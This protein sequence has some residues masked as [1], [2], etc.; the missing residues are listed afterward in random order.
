MKL[1]DRIAL[2]FALLTS[3]IL[4]LMGLLLFVLYRNYIQ[5][6]FTTRLHERCLIAA[7]LYFDREKLSEVAIESIYQKHLRTLPNEQEYI[8]D[9]EQKDSMLAYLPSFLAQQLEGPLSKQQEYFKAQSQDTVGVGILY[10]DM[11]GPHF[12]VVTAINRQ[13]QQE[14]R[15]LGNILAGLAGVYLVG[16]F[17]IAR[18]YARQV[19][20]PLTAMTEKMR[21]VNTAN[22]HVR[23]DPLPGAHPDDELGSIV[24]AFNK[25]LGRLETS[26]EVQRNFITHASHQL[27]TPLTTILG[28]IELARQQARALP[29]A[30]IESL[31]HI[32]E[33]SE[34]LNRLILRLLHL[35]EVGTEINSLPS[36]PVRVDELLFKIQEELLLDY[37]GRPLQIDTGTFPS[38]PESLEVSG[39][40][41]LLQIALFNLAENGLKYSNSTVTVCLSVKPGL[42]EVLIQDRGPGIPPHEREAVFTPFVRGQGAQAIPGYGVG[43]P[44][45]Q[46][47]IAL[48]GGEVVLASEGNKGALAIVRLPNGQGLL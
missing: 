1:R 11:A 10:R 33:E 41:N 9:L 37:P 14:V 20:S 13:G 6:E 3:S 16:I 4:F 45:A 36:N 2:N 24:E 26:V 23:L 17:F 7:Q 27:K 21:L 43:L 25:M 32:S 5:H 8:F 19:L 31:S 35:A 38:A 44:L 15:E 40:A 22:L 12:V 34:R 46:K 48:H 39:D 42:L 29:P 30:V 47:I 28:E 18:W